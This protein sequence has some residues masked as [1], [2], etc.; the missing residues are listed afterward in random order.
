[1][2]RDEPTD[3]QTITA[4]ELIAYL[5]VGL[6]SIFTINLALDWAG[7]QLGSDIMEIGRRRDLG[8]VLSLVLGLLLTRKVAAWTGFTPKK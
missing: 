2:K 7:R 8:F 5:V 1:M 3:R 4:I 6:C